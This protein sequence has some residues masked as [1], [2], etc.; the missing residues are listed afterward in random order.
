MASLRGNSTLLDGDLAADTASSWAYVGSATDVTLFIDDAGAS[1][2]WLI[3]IA[4]GNGEP[5]LNG[6]DFADPDGLP[7]AVLSDR[8]GGA[9]T[10]VTTGT[11]V[12]VNLSPF[13][14][15]YIR[16]RPDGDITGGLV[17]INCVA[18]NSRSLRGHQVLL[19]NED[20][21]SGDTSV[22]GFIGD[23]TNAVLFL[24]NDVAAD[25]FDIEVAA[26]TGSPGMNEVPADAA[27]A[28]LFDANGNQ[29]QFQTNVAG[30]AAIDLSP[31]GSSF[32]RLKAQQ[33]S[34]GVTATL[35]VTD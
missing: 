35:A 19:D 1:A 24:N 12:A 13:A 4:I 22:I 14:S 6:V 10:V 34:T 18:R 32:I 27:F 3:E 20:V 7:W 9:S 26:G 15:Q 33:D 21:A 8:T 28:L 23:E 5:G 17:T 16:V 30:K 29:V 11:P 31:I 2:T 25:V